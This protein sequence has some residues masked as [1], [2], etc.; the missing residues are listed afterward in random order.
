MVD[1]IKLRDQTFY[2]LDKMFKWTDNE[3]ISVYEYKRHDYTKLKF[4]T[5]SMVESFIKY[6]NFKINFSVKNLT[7][8]KMFD[9]NSKII[10]F[11]L[12]VNNDDINNIFYEIND[13]TNITKSKYKLETFQIFTNCYYTD[14]DQYYSNLVQYIDEYIKLNI[15]KL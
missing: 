4:V 6:N 1:N 10:T 5:D 9:F 8:I 3:D 11:T 2:L 7:S 12:L 15:D 14:V 13:I